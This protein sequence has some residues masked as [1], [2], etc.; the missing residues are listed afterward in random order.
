MKVI[1]LFCGAGGF[2]EGFRQ[3]GFDIILGVDSWVD[4]LKSYRHNQKCD[5]L[6]SDI[7]DVTTLPNCD[8]IIGSPPCQNFSRLNV[9]KKVWEGLELVREFERIVKLNKP[10]YWV[11][12]NIDYIKR[13]YRG[14]S[15]LNSWDCGLAQRRKRAFVA[16]FQFFRM[17]YVKGKLTPLYGY[18]GHLSSNNSKAALAHMTRSGTVRTKR[19]RNLET[20]EFLS[21]KE[22]KKLMGFFKDYFL[23]G[24]VI[25]QQKQLGNAVSPPVAKLFAEAIL[26]DFSTISSNRSASEKQ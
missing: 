22:V 15:L 6:K 18:D 25:S 21:I 3:A 8:V 19:I 14:A 26:E 5:V 13:F 10:K 17:S 2:S 7:R 9:K 11:W 20:G 1:D 16:N 24:G 12:E 4:A 23:Y